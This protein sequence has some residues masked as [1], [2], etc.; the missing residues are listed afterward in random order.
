[1]SQQPSQRVGT[2][3]VSNQIFFFFFLAMSC[4]T[5]DLNSLTMDQTCA[6]A[7]EA[8]SLNHCTAR[9]VP[10][11]D[12]LSQ[13]LQALLPPPNFPS[14]PTIVSL[15]QGFPGGSD[16]KESACNAGEPGS[17]PGLGRSPGEGNGHHSSILAWRISWTEEPG[18][19]HTVHGVTQN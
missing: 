18:G 17:I 7:V 1:M 13:Q 5:Q 19:L 2:Q 9:E 12:S 3:E 11:P 6:P 16:G 8:P 14:N 4:N 10:E 15:C